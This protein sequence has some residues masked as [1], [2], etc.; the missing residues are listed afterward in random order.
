MYSTTEQ[1]LLTTDSDI[2]SP[3]TSKVNTL[4]SYEAD[5]AV[6][7]VA[8]G[9][10][11]AFIS[12]TPL[13]TRLFEINEIN[14]EQPPLLSDV[15]SVIPELIPE[16]VNSM[17]ASPALSIVSL[18]LQVHQIFSNIDSWKRHAKSER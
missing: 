11:Q 8:L 5:A 4:S 9:T 15:T 2:L 1:F 13:Y 12:K 3:K 14:S 7:S 16:T 17:V 6:E 18:G 10:S